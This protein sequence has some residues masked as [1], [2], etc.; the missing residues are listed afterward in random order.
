MPQPY[1]RI[2]L[3]DLPKSFVDGP[4]EP[5]AVTWESPL[6]LR[7]EVERFAIYFRREFSYDFQ[8]FSATEKPKKEQPYAAYLFTNETNHYPRVWVGACCFRW[9]KYQDAEPRW[10][11]QWA[12]LHPYY[13]GKGIL[14]GA[15]D[16]F[17]ELH[18]NFLPEPPY[19]PAMEAF[20]RK[21]GKCIFC[22][23]PLDVPEKVVC[24]H[25]DAQ[26]KT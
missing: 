21:R 20:L 12:W 18:G 11:A 2:D 4:G 7:R 9:R 26:H 5:I 10:G 1:Y 16:R 24:A 25:C 23:Q 13:R 14:S 17:H 6:K 19:S 22:W 15:W 3:N 8:Q